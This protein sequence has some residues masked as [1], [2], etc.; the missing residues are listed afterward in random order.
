MKPGQML[1]LFVLDM[2][3]RGPLH[4]HNWIF[5]IFQKFHY[6]IW[7]VEIC[8]LIRR[9]FFQCLKFK[10]ILRR[11]LI[12]WTL[13][14]VLFKIFWYILNYNKGGGDEGGLKMAKKYNDL[15]ACLQI[16]IGGSSFFTMNGSTTHKYS[17]LW[18]FCG[19]PYVWYTGGRCILNY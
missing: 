10:Q 7:F 3:G 9:I 18:Y 12:T 5:T 8:L 19:P 4:Y 11:A 14:I 17:V 6:G 16:I 13:I 1:D 15:G 2:G